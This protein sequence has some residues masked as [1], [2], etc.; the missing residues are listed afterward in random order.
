[1]I[2]GF[3]TI[4][5]MGTCIK[6][7]TTIS[8]NFFWRS[9]KVKELRSYEIF[10][11]GNFSV[12]TQNFPLQLSV[13]PTL[14]I[15]LCFSHLFLSPTFSIFHFMCSLLVSYFASLIFFLPSSSLL[16]SYA[17]CTKLTNGLC[18]LSLYLLGPRYQDRTARL[19]WRQKKVNETMTWTG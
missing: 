5:S 1:M 16:N 7:F 2:F 11:V 18:S 19:Q 14:D 13:T 17:S 4:Q 12:I 3:D 6:L 15:K 9:G 8:P 10:T